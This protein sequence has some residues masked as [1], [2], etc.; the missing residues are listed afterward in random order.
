MGGW[1]CSAAFGLTSQLHGVEYRVYGYDQQKTV[2]NRQP[3]SV[4]N[5][6][7]VML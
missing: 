5:D 3:K 1:I 2:R 7:V 4:L 6:Q